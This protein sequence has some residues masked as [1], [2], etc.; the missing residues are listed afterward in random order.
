MRRLLILL[1]ASVA[2]GALS[3]CEAPTPIK[4]APEESV[5]AAEAQPASAPTPYDYTV[6]C[7]TEGD[8]TYYG[9]KNFRE[10]WS[11]PVKWVDCEE[12]YRTGSF[13]TDTQEAALKTAGY[14]DGID[15]LGTLYSLCASLHVSEYGRM[16]DYSSGQIAEISGALLICPDQP[17]AAALRD[18]LGL[19]QQLA[20]ARANGTRF[21]SGIYRVG[22][23]IKPGTYAVQGN[24]TDCYWERRDSSG[25]ILGNNFI[26]QGPRA[27][28]TVQPG[29]YSFSTSQCGEWSLA[30]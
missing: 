28:V 6:K 3:A 11:N 4:P 18:R 19:S 12:K 17:A 8:F 15:S 2:V 27:E 21:N 20:T 26:A 1:A 7:H 30:G 14:D 16:P 29:D 23:D 22:V 10:V 5:A 25:T 9:F 24:L 13:S